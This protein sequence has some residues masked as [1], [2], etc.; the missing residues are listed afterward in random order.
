MYIFDS[1]LKKKVPFEPQE[2]GIVRMYVCGPTVYDYSHLGHARSAI[3]FDLLRRTLSALG[4]KVIMAKNF[5]DIDDKIIKKAYEEGKEIGE[6]TGFFIERYL[7]EMEALNVLRPEFEPKA[8]DYLDAMGNMIL[9]LLK[10]GCAYKTSNGDVYLDTTKDPLYGSLSAK[11]DDE[12]QSRIE[13]DKEKRH[14]RD[15]VLWKSCKEGEERF[16]YKLDGL[17]KGRPG[18]HIECS[19]MIEQIFPHENRSYAI[20]IH[21]GGVDLL[22]PHHENEACQT[23]C[24][25]KKEIAKYWMHNGFVTIE[26][27]KMSK[28]LKNSFFIKD[29]LEVVSGEVLRFYLMSTHYRA[30]LNFNHQDMF[31]SKKRLDKLYRL[32][33]RVYGLKE[34]EVESGFKEALLEP[35]SDDLNISVAL[36]VI[37]EFIKSSNEFLDSGKKNRPKKEAIVANISF[38]D[39]VLG[40]GGSDAYAYFQY[41]LTGE[42]KSEIEALIKERDAAKRAKDYAKADEI[43][44]ILSRINIDIMDTPNGTVWERREE[45]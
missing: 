1:K 38:I 39:K 14:I 15:F 2:S 9:T 18:W 41:G 36:S 10:E 27:E 35:L 45:G 23:R 28:S 26:G 7:E 6:I 24:A 31:A 3:S 33:K 25:T 40:V 43:R 19:S 17:A 21:G 11:V 5:T 37:D 20:D 42:Q 13:N 22:F 8:T 44:E 12:A 34:G 4:L 32:K 29:A 16:C 30:P